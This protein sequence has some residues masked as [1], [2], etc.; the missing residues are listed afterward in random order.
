MKKQ[1]V[2]R[3]AAIL[4]CCNAF[5][6]ALGFVLR[7]V[8]SRLLGAE[9]VGVMELSH[10]AHMLSITP[11]TA[12]VPLAVSRMTA[13]DQNDRALCAGFQLILR[14]SLCIM[15]IWLLLSP[16]IAH[17]LNEMRVLPSLLFF[18]PCI[19]IL[20]LSAICNGYSYGCGNAWPPAISEV[21]EQLLRFS[22]SAALLLSLPYLS[23]AYRAAVPALAT[24][25][26]EGVGLL[27]T[28]F[29]LR[30]P[31]R[32]RRDL[33]SAQREI[34]AL[35]LPLM[36]SRLLTT[37]LRTA[38]GALIPQ[39]LIVSGLTSAQALEQFGMLQGMVMPVLFLPGIVTGALG[40]VGTPAIAAR[41]G[42]SQQHMAVGLFLSALICGTLGMTAVH[43]LSPFLAQKIYA[44]PH[45][46]PLFRHAAPLTVLFSLQH[47]V[48][49]VMSG[50]GEQKRLLL[51]ALLSSLL[52]L[53]LLYF[54]A[55]QPH[56]RI[57]GAVRAMVW[58]QAASVMWGLALVWRY[59]GKGTGRTVLS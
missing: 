11:V 17:L 31:M 20:G 26:A 38:S 43:A 21:V 50:L 42:K 40:T 12:G 36:L 5:T 35:S 16:V 1:S 54:W 15:P 39:R 45:L 56:T 29:L 58:S 30:L 52:S 14:L 8:L 23:T 34:L 46:T 7:I 19:L 24:T 28:F 9:A 10:S 57:L 48:N 2:R 27:L 18:T 37:L 22:L 6:R 49:G 55:A 51:P 44:L 59:E 4:T 25:V 32:P 13:R 33:Q 53:I 47:A 41:S 3:Q